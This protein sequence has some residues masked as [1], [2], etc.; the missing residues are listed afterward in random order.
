MERR[1]AERP[2]SLRKELPEGRGLGRHSDSRVQTR[3]TGADV[4][5]ALGEKRAW[6]KDDGRETTKLLLDE[7]SFTVTE[8]RFL[9]ERF[10]FY[11]R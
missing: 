2:T 1:L 9:L 8:S 4:G 3:W 7:V 6:K 5:L 11:K 10:S